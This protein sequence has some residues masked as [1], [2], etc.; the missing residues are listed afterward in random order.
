MNIYVEESIIK[1][2]ELNKNQ[3]QK[4]NSISNEPPLKIPML[5]AVPEIFVS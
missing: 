3:A 2:W 4:W 1:Y 5:T